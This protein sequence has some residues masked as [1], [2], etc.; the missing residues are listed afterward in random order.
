MTG[1]SP[2]FIDGF[3]SSDIDALSAFD[4]IM[5]RHGSA[6]EAFTAGDYECAL[7]MSHRENKT[8][9]FACSLV[10]CGAIDRGLAALKDFNDASDVALICRAYG[11][12]LQMDNERATA[13]LDQVENKNWQA[14]AETFAS[15]LTQ[16]QYN[17]LIVA[18]VPLQGVTDSIATTGVNIKI[19]K[20]SENNW[21]RPIDTLVPPGFRPDLIL[22]LGVF[23]QHLPADVFETSATTVFYCGDVDIGINIQYADLCRA[24][25]IICCSCHERNMLS[26]L[27]P[28]RVVTF[29]G[30]IHLRNSIPFVDQVSAKELDV[31]LTGHLFRPYMTGKARF[32]YQLAIT[33]DPELKV[34]LYDGYLDADAYA[35]MTS[36]SRLVPTYRRFAG[37]FQ[38]RT[39]DAIRSGTQALESANISERLLLIKSAFM[40]ETYSESNLGKNVDETLSRSDVATMLFNENAP[41]IK[42]EIDDIFLEPPERDF[43]LAKFAL[44]QSNF[45]SA[46]K[47]KTPQLSRKHRLPCNWRFR[48]FAK[49]DE[50]EISHFAKLALDPDCSRTDLVILT[51]GFIDLFCRAPT[52]D[53]ALRLAEKVSDIAVGRYPNAIALR[54]NR[55]RFHWMRGN[56]AR[57]LE[58]FNWLE[59]SIQDG[60]LDVAR[61]NLLS[62]LIHAFS[63]VMPY[64]V[65]YRSVIVDLQSGHASGP[66][67]RSVILATTLVYLAL[68]LLQNENTTE[69]IEKL[70]QAVT[71]CPGHF[72]AARLLTKAL[73]NVDPVESLDWFYRAIKF[74]PPY[75]S[76]LLPF[77]V[78]LERRAGNDLKAVEIVRNWALFVSRV[79]WSDQDHHGLSEETLKAAAPYL[80]RLEPKIKEMLIEKLTTL[81]EYLDLDIVA[82]VENYR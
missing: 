46:P 45:M 38:T 21:T 35:T 22:S 80:D 43:R 69:G 54:F 78:D 9:L 34:K 73:W 50:L 36:R 1:L 60:D 4:T 56:H 44:L 75:L 39:I 40:V 52:D 11:H 71:L 30:H 62:H 58:D 82:L 20:A 31:T 27:Y 79:E 19:L 7:I 64:E 48:H 68:N 10:M 28:A 24:D 17:V 41:G 67:S 12:W 42:S 16:K 13:L 3:S 49:L 14:A 72:P 53:I 23:G 47:N 5:R 26:H 55:G 29:P 33:S 32:A 18:P 37:G 76:E 63:N 57:A 77:G 15:K 66:K 6:Q 59:Q 70:Q 25:L 8:E 65:Y 2:V 51:N 74:Y 61:E 81:S